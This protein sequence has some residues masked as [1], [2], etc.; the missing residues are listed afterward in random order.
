MRQA[1]W[2]HTRKQKK[3]R[4]V[5]ITRGTKYW[6]PKIT[7]VDDSAELSKARPRIPFQQQLHDVLPAADLET[8]QVQLTDSAPSPSVRHL[9][10]VHTLPLRTTGAS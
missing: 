6:P 1:R 9:P 5:K 7:V 3:E 4:K 10:R 8:S 2:E